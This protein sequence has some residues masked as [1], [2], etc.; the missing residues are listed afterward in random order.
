M[1][2]K[3]FKVS[4]D[5]EKVDLISLSNLKRFWNDVFELE[6]ENNDSKNENARYIKWCGGDVAKFEDV[7]VSGDDEMIKSIKD[8]TDK[9][10]NEL[11]EVHHTISKDY[12][13]GVDGEFFDVGILLSGEPEHWFKETIM[14]GKKELPRVEINING[15]YSHVVKSETVIENACLVLAYCK[16]FEMNGVQTKINVHFVSQKEHYSGVKKS[17]YVTTAY[18]YFINIKDF[19]DKISYYKLSTVLHP[20]FFRRGLLR[21]K[22]CRWNGKQNDNYGEPVEHSDHIQLKESGDIKRKFEKFF[23]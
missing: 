13:L 2:E 17:R 5:K 21:I 1:I 18:D 15:A 8:V 10:L 4:K 22:E 7:L 19:E 23:E 3:Y 9:K 11:L 6:F 14:D 12:L 20:I 16:L